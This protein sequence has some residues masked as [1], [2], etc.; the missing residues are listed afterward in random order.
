MNSSDWHYSSSDL[1]RSFENVGIEAGDT[2]FFHVGLELLG[3]LKD[4]STPDQANEMFMDALRTVVGEEGTILMPSYSFSFCRR[5]I[6]DVDNTPAAP[7]PWSTSTGFLEYFRKLPGVVRSCDPIHSIAGLGRQAEMLLRNLPN[8][9]FGTDSVFDRIR[10]VDG[11]ICVI[12]LGLEEATFR[13]HVE[14]MIGVPF[15][16]KKL[17]TGIIREQ[18]KTRKAGWIYNVRILADNG[19]PDGERLE[20]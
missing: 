15:R 2:V 11:K 5:E 4:A 20:Q 8:S 19:F 13:H 7:G 14:E 10:Q 1:I 12:G 3:V 9:C 16:F 6:F 17:F 18:G